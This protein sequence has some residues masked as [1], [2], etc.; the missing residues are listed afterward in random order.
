L[1]AYQNS[2]EYI[3]KTRGG[4]FHSLWQ[5]DLGRC[6]EGQ[7]QRVVEAVALVDGGWWLK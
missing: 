1:S 7:R 5:K 3:E 4:E 2:S 6:G